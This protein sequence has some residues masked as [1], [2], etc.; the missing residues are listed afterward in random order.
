M[1]SWYSFT[2]VNYHSLGTTYK[3]EALICNF[4]SW[5]GRA[6]YLISQ[7]LSAVMLNRAVE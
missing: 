7:H 2:S 1:K 4:V 5:G 3:L 6:S